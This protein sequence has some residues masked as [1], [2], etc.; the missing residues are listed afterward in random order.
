M[1]KFD[2]QKY[3]KKNPS[4][5]I[6][7]INSSSDGFFHLGVV[8][9]IL[10]ES[11][12]IWQTLE[13]LNEAQRNFAEKVLV[14]L[15]F[16]H[17]A[18]TPQNYID[19]NLKLLDKL[20]HSPF[21]YPELNLSIIDVQKPLRYAVGEAR[22]IGMDSIIKEISPD[23][24][25]AKNSIIIS[26]DGDTIVENDYFNKISKFFKENPKT[27]AAAFEVVHQKSN[28]EKIEKAIRHYEE[29]LEKYYLALQEAD[30]PFAYKSVGSAF[31]VRV[32]SYI[33]SGGM[34]K[35]RA[36]EDFYFLEAV[37][38]IGRIDFTRI[39]TVHPSPRI[40]KRVAFGTGIAVEEI[41]N[42][43]NYPHFG[44]KAIR[45][46]KKLLASATN[47]N[48]TSVELF[49]KLQ[50]AETK[51]FLITHNFPILWGKVLKNY[52][53]EKLSNQFKYYYFDALK[54]LQFLKIWQ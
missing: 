28:D 9:P 53:T 18:K 50:T 8:I 30:S 36:G 14:L 41:I 34:R 54:T 46:L 19:D 22:K 27:D 47:E 40:S 39:I 20:R 12:F 16:N 31:A 29:Y 7:K 32:S 11:E 51:E 52:P 48:L 2:F 37:A 26:L 10:G 13:K 49:L 1:N 6:E 15:V 23:Y 4:D 24:S 3:L 35:E 17:N 42:G 21:P 5:L 38:K 33:R 25:M 45:E 43:K 44:N